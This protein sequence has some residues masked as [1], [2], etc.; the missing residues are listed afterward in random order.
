MGI[1]HGTVSPMDGQ[2]ILIRHDYPMIVVRSRKKL[3]KC[4]NRHEQDY[5]NLE[6]VHKKSEKEIY[7]STIAF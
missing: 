4:K 5:N 6:K 2:L 3:E 7:D 1:T